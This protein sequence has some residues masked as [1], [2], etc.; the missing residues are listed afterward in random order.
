MIFNCECFFL[1]SEIFIDY[2]YVLIIIFVI[3]RGLNMFIV[4]YCKGF[5][6]LNCCSLF[7]F[8]L[9]LGLFFVYS[10]YELY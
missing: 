10:L 6:I 9:G 1:F 3:G 5:V 8:N 4:I 7:F 2:Y